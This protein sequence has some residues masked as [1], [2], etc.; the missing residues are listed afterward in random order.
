MNGAADVIISSWK[1]CCPTNEHYRWIARCRWPP[2][3][4]EIPGEKTRAPLSIDGA[5]EARRVCC[6]DGVNKNQ[7]MLFWS[8]CEGQF[9]SVLF[10]S[11][12]SSQ[13]SL[14]AVD[15]NNCSDS[16]SPGSVQFRRAVSLV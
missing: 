4:L 7:L 15:S 14:T 6:C 10:E 5:M 2:I 8:E 9:E 11:Q 13:E 12:R 1:L 3:S 16:D